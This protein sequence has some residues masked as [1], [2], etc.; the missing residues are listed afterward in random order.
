ML[1]ERARH[2]MSGLEVEQPLDTFE[3][4]GLEAKELEEQVTDV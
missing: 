3:L 4:V 2:E 1:Q